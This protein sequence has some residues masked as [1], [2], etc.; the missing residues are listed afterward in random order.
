[1]TDNV[2]PVAF[3]MTNSA[4]RQSIMDKVAADVVSNSNHLATGILGTKWLLPT[5][6]EYGYIE[7]AYLL[8]TQTTYPSWGYW[9]S[10]GATTLWEGWPVSARSHGHQFFGTVVDWFYQDFAGIET[11]EAGFASVSISPYVPANLSSAAGTVQTAR[12]PVTSSWT[13][14]T[15]QFDLNVENLSGSTGLL[16]LPVT[17][18]KVVY[19][20]GRPVASAR[21]VTF[22]GSS[23][24]RTSFKLLSGS[25]QFTVR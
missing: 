5:L 1:M 13:N 25:Y 8:A 16:Q 23:H 24:D 12:G 18:G 9:R 20:S 6:T 4:R 19:E 2:L 7:L 14:T 22:L 17:K 3:G 21:G 11:T 10:T 15:R